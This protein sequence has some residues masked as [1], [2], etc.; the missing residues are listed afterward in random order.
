VSQIA[1]DGGA[2]I[3]PLPAPGSGSVGSTGLWTFLATDAMGFGGLLL[4]Y[5]V[6]RV[7]AGAGTWPDP[8]AHLAL[9]P[10]AAMTFA[11]LASSLTMTLASRARAAPARRGWLV[12]TLALGVAF[13][14]GA[15][16]EYRHLLGSATPMGLTSHLFASTF[17]VVTGFHA[18][19]VLAGVVGLGFMFRAKIGAQVTETFALYWHFVD[20]MWMPI[21]T[22]VYLWPTR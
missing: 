15:A 10:A 21:F 5:G 4:A 22:L 17:Y 13:L 11:L 6:L 3:A 16:I 18:L 2:K 8:R 1:I 20:A 9:A 12:A 19:H 14:A 7:R